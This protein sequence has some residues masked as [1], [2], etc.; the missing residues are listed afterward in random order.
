MVAS[1][2]RRSLVAQNSGTGD[3][4]LADGLPRAGRWLLVMVI[5]PDHRLS[6]QE[7]GNVD[8]GTRNRRSGSLRSGLGSMPAGLR[9]PTDHIAGIGSSARAYL[10]RWQSQ[11][12]GHDRRSQCV[13]RGPPSPRPPL[14]TDRVGVGRSPGLPTAAAF[15]GPA[16][17]RS[18][19]RIRP[20]GG[21]WARELAAAFARLHGPTPTRLLTSPTRTSYKGHGERRLVPVGQ[22]CPPAPR[23]PPA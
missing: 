8:I 23:R 17:P 13:R 16:D 9:P 6:P 10:R 3:G 1:R 7:Y 11:P 19:L 20:T 15:C 18:R 5:A 21:P 12:V 22:L 14:A 2:E 4:S